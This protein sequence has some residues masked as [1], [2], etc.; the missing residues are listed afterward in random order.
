MP[1]SKS[2]ISSNTNRS[3]RSSI[4]SLDFDNP[5][6]DCVLYFRFKKSEQADCNL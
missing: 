2:E 5:F 6:P 4:R 1:I 3:Q